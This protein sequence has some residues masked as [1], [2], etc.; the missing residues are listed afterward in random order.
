MAIS[1]NLQL[2]SLQLVT[3]YELRFEAKKV[4][5]QGHHDDEIFRR[6]QNDRL[7]AVNNNIIYHKMALDHPSS[8]KPARTIVVYRPI[9]PCSA[10]SLE[11]LVPRL[12][13][14]S[15]MP[16]FW[17]LKTATLDTARK[18][19]TIIA[20]EI[21]PSNVLIVT[22]L[23]GMQTRSSDENS[24]CPSNARTVTKLKK[25]KPKS[26]FLANVN[27]SSCSLYVVVRPSVVC[28][29][30]VVCRLSVCL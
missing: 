15:H 29:S 6:R 16:G 27:S 20:V 19:S 28:L 2:G 1:P 18:Q 17:N 30:S 8:Q 24:V 23:H 7:F 12:S 3:G 4:K 10:P 14:P 13:Y 9:I 25:N 11:Q 22:A 21:P 5:G 26:R